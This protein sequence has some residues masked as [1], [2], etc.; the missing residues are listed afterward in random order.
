MSLTDEQRAYVDQLMEAIAK[1]DQSLWFLKSDERHAVIGALADG[2]PAVTP[3]M[4]ERVLQWADEVRR[5]AGILDNI[6]KGMVRIHAQ[7]NGSVLFSLT[8][9]GV[10][11]AEDL[12]AN[13]HNK[14]VA[15]E[16][17]G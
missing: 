14:H 12:I 8:E 5:D 2:T 17:R 1:S 9:D 7:P 11:S 13:M 15:R 6:L 3:Q 10:K 16:G 4:L